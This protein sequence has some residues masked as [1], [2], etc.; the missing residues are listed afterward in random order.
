MAEKKNILI[1]GLPGSGKTTLVKKL[2][3]A[4]ESMNPVGFYTAEI[5]QGGVR[6]GFELIGLAGERSL[7][8]HVDIVSRFRVGKYGV[9]IAR[10]D[11]FLD[12]LDFGNP[13]NSMIII[14]EI[15][16]MECG[17]AKFVQLVESLLDSPMPVVAVVAMK[18]GGIIKRVKSRDDTILFELTRDNRDDLPGEILPIIQK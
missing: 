8:S 16:K 17:S 7:L 9:D 15:G 3:V 12:S 11:K 1:T 6:K 14:D 4:L 5:R 2:A 13:L 18:G 10:F